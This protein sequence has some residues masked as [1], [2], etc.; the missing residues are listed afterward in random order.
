MNVKISTISLLLL[1]VLIL[2]ISCNSGSEES[3]A[4][5]TDEKGYAILTDDQVQNI[6]MRS[7]Q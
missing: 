2:I 6:V 3:A 5:K 7:Y 4:V 1:S